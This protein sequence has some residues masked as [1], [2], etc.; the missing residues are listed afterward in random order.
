MYVFF[1]GS[2]AFHS[3]SIARLT[4]VP[5]IHARIFEPRQKKKMSAFPEGTDAG[6]EIEGAVPGSTLD[7]LANPAPLTHSF[8]SAA[9]SAV[10]QTDVKPSRSNK[11][12]MTPRHFSRTSG[13]KQRGSEW[14]I[15]SHTRIAST[16]RIAELR[17]ST[18]NG[19]RVTCGE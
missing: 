11:T 2:M 9:G 1:A 12:G 4:C 10:R 6:G 3:P 17:T 8:A 13:G 19:G 7:A 5:F 18:A 14:Q 15:W 16:R